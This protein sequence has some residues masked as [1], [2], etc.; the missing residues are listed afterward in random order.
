MA[1][2][3][4]IGTL[5]SSQHLYRRNTTT[6][7]GDWRNVDEAEVYVVESWGEGFMLGALLIMA[8]ITVA[9]MRKKVLL[10]KLILLEVR[11]SL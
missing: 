9:N 4:T 10:H 5:S 2:V 8:A 3:L 1:P 6:N 11:S 7:Y